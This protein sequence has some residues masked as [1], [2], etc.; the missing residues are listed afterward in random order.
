V[1]TDPWQGASYEKLSDPQFRWGEKVLERLSLAGTETVLDAGCGTGRLTGLVLERLP[2]GRVIAVDKSASMLAIARAKLV[3]QYG[4]RVTL[5]EADLQ[6]FVAPAPVDAIFSTATFHWVL[7][8]ARLFRNLFASLVPG[9]R[10]E[11]QCGGGPN[12]ARLH[13]RAERLMALDDYARYFRDWRQPW[14]F[15]EPEV[16]AARLRAAGF[17]RVETGLEEQPTTFADA[18]TFREFITTIVLHAHVSCLP[19]PEGARFIDTLVAEAAHDRPPY[20]LDY[21]RLNLRGVRPHPA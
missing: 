13:A 15:A 16:T 5:I 1:T 3:P 17:D 21:W 19:E 4:A 14:T 12:V 20:T 11:A 7:D 18:E 9:G 2:R 10:L 6:T 8:H